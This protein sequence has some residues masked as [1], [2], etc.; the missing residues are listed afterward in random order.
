MHNEEP[1]C[2]HFDMGIVA[3]SSDS[4]YILGHGIEKANNFLPFATSH[5][6]EYGWNEIGVESTEHVHKICEGESLNGFFMTFGRYGCK[7]DI[8]KMLGVLVFVIS[9]GI[10]VEG[11]THL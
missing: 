4:I 9:C 1:G 2:H 8:L 6:E 11:Y 7:T 3:E 10:L 5:A